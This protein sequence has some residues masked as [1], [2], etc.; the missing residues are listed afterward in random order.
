[1]S[2]S[3]ADAA[4][5]SG[6]SIDTLRYYERV[7][8]IEPPARDSGGRRI[9]TD[10]D[11]SWL[12]FLTK[13]RTTGMPI[14]RMHEYAVLRRQGMAGAGA[15]KRILAEQRTAVVE[16]I[17]ELRSCLDALDYKIDNCERLERRMAASAAED[18]TAEDDTREAETKEEVSA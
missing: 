9:Y 6:L 16:R 18:D 12:E 2:Y 5:Y 7:Q 4:R 14:R 11:L 8:L 3:I 1:M 15:R 17:A 13:L 10:A